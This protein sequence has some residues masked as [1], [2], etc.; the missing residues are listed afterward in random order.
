MIQE[1]NKNVQLFHHVQFGNLRVIQQNNEPW[2]VARDVCDALEV[3]NPSDAIKRLDNDERARLNLG[4]Q[5]EANI[6][7]FPG[8]L[9]LILGSRKKEAREYKRWVTHEVLPSI[10]KHGGYLTPAK[11]EEALLNPDTIIQLATNL[12]EEQE[13]RKAL[14]AENAAMQPKALF[15]DAVAA[16]HTS[17]LIGDLA[18]LIKQ[19][20]VDIGQRRLFAWM[21][22]NGWLMKQGSSKNLPTQR[23]MERGLFEVKESTISNPDGSIRTTKTTKVT[24]KGQQYF[25]NLFL[26]KNGEVA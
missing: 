10:H 4:R 16:S 24:G 9:S 5:G 21:R 7:S 11:I 2:F 8:L 20:G 13:K 18:K 14:E 6:I 26:N 19:N 3:K 15:A 17:I 1:T 22:E 12:K 23:G 25:I